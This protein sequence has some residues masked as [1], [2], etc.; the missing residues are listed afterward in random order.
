[1]NPHKLHHLSRRLRG[2]PVR[3][4]RKSLK[5][6]A[7]AQRLYRTFERDLELANVNGV[8]FYVK[9]G[10]VTL[11][12]TIRHELDRELLVSLVQQIAGVRRVEEQLQIVAVPFQDPQSEIVLH[13]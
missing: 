12:G 4:S 3:D 8:H 9:N 2:T 5:D 1:M 13:L 11:Y 10:T 7:L 6:K